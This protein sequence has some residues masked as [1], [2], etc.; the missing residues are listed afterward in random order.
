MRHLAIIALALVLSDRT[1]AGR[2]QPSASAQ[3][4]ST[5]TLPAQVLNGSIAAFNRHDA[6]A[7]AAFFDSSFTHAFLESDTAGTPRHVRP[8]TLL[9]QMTAYFKSQK[10]PPQATLVHSLVVGPFIT[11]EYRIVDDSGTKR[12]L[13]VLEVRH[14]K[15]V[16]EWEQQAPYRSTPTPRE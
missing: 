4:A 1:L 5:D 16:A 12:A 6:R 8:D 15:F 7:F 2:G 3:R 10:K 9:A 11:W 14:G 13:D